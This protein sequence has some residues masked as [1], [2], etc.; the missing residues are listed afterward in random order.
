MDLQNK[1]NYLMLRIFAKFVSSG[2][3]GKMESA[4]RLIWYKEVLTASLNNLPVILMLHEED[5]RSQDNS[6][7]EIA[8]LMMQLSTDGRARLAEVFTQFTELVSTKNKE[9]INRMI[10]WLATGQTKLIQI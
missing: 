5:S 7:S 2:I 3:T 8:K 4:E 10:V 1:D 9:P 6:G